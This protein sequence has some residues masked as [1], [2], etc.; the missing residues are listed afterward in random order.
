[1]PERGIDVLI[2][3]AGPVGCALALGLKE[4]PLKVALLG[5]SARTSPFRPIALSYAS[6]L[7][8]ERL[9]VWEKLQ[10]TP[11]ESIL[12]S[13]QQGFGRMRMDAADAGV[14][15]LGYVTDY[16]SLLDILR[17]K[18]HGLLVDEAPP[19]RCVVHAE[20][21]APEVEEKRYPQDAVVAL[22]RTRPASSVTAF[23]RFTS[24]GPLA[25]LPYRGRYALIWTCRPERA[26]L[27]SKCSEELFLKELAAAAGGRPGQPVEV[28][29][30]LVQPL[31]L[32][33][34][35]T[36][37]APREVYIG[38]AAQ[39]LHPV[40]GQ[41]LNLGLRDAWDLAAAF[42]D[43]EDPGDER[44]LLRYAASRRLD[45]QAAIRIT[46]ALA[47]AFLGSGR[48]RRAARGAALTALDIFPAPRRFFARR[49][50]FGPSA[51]P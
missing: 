43:A 51:L 16:Q 24:E 17:D 1:M 21:V 9:G 35:A 38:N 48:L 33:V 22:V 7:V 47:D 32:R 30:R 19:A 10:V 18:A 5:A 42:R 6:R 39:T 14:P 41:G 13:Q 25:L 20:G 49:M 36:R 23:E 37:V 40:A 2:R 27:L 4:S 26:A 45:A 3:G 44:L 8:L 11:I 28:E 31:V 46:D 29:G 34:R 50:M 15:A 12:V